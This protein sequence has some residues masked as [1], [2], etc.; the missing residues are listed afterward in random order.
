MRL[1]GPWP[2]NVRE[3]ENLV[4]RMVTLTDHQEFHV[5]DLPEFPG[6]MRP[7]SRDTHLNEFTLPSDGIDIDQCIQRFQRQMMVQALERAHG[8][9]TAGGGSA[10]NLARRIDELLLK[11]RFYGSRQMVRHLWRASVWVVT[12]CAV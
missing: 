12:R 11:Y 10:T 7:D 1:P 2:G 5:D 9:K 8:N 6:Y 4:E 3:T